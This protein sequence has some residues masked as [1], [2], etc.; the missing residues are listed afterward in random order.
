MQ[1]LIFDYVRKVHTYKWSRTTWYEMVFLIVLV[2]CF[3]GMRN[4]AIVYLLV[5][6]FIFLYLSDDYAAS[7]Y[8]NVLECCS[9]RLMHVEDGRIQTGELCT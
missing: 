7:K 8:Y 2:A 9:N 4:L 3:V 1:F 5:G 6:F